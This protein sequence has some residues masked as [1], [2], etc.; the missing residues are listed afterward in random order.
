MLSVLILALPVL[1]LRPGA[2]APLGR[3]RSAVCVHAGGTLQPRPTAPRSF[4]GLRP[5]VE[6]LPA[7]AE[8]PGMIVFDL[9]NTL[10]TPELYT[11]RRLKGYADASPPGPTAWRDV[12]LV[13]GAA[14][15]LHELATSE[16]W[17]AAGTV[18]AVASRTTKGPWARSLLAQ[19]EVP[20]VPRTNGRAPTLDALLPFKQIRRGDKSA[21]VR[22]LSAESGVPC[23]RMLF[24][25]DARGGRYGNCEPVARLGVLAVHTPQGLTRELFALGLAEYARRRHRGLPTGG[26][27]PQL[28]EGEE[29][30]AAGAGAGGVAGEAHVAEARLW[31]ADPAEGVVRS[32][33][34]DRGFGFVR[35]GRADIFFHSSAIVGGAEPAPR[36]GERVRVRVRD[37]A[38]GRRECERVERVEPGGGARPTGVPTVRMRCFSM[39]MPFAALLGHGYKSLETRN[40]TMFAQGARPGE[41]LLLHVGRRIYP[42]GGAHKEL[43]RAHGASEAE[44]RELTSLPHGFGRGQIVAVLELGETQLMSDERA[45][46]APEVERRVVATGQAM[47][48]YLTEVVR[49]EWLEEPVPMRGQPGIFDVE[50]PAAALPDGWRAAAADTGGGSRAS[51]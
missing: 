46:C 34:E 47:G 7:E 30:E 45:R 41:R 22:A 8:L 4:D 44:I 28:A 35:L 10:W 26:V 2:P 37:A 49:A 31:G 9:D 13:D 11:L 5:L 27:L 36:P 33:L 14:D 1:A 25:D 42:D 32:W 15:V 50:I 17:Q 20:G 16:R 39:N 21:H 38:D 12:W 48:R 24:F 3:A 19:F 23:E 6:S 29:T 18:L 40:G 43:M 51:R